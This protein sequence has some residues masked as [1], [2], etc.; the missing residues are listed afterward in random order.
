MIP[1]IMY[2]QEAKFGGSRCIHCQC[3]QNFIVIITHPC[4]THTPKMCAYTTFTTLS[5]SNVCMYLL[6]YRARF[7]TPVP[8]ISF[9]QQIIHKCYICSYEKFH[10]RHL[11]ILCVVPFGCFFQLP[12]FLL[13]WQP[14][15]DPYASFIAWILQFFPHNKMHIFK[16]RF[17]N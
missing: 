1:N 10:R 11:T 4:N 13:E 16:I 8:K 2:T 3:L 7:V 14:I 9:P 17:P 15:N 12:Y 5:T 6:F